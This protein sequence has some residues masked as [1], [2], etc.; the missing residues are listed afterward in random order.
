M[1]LGR[2]L[3]GGGRRSASRAG[4]QQDKAGTAVLQGQRNQSGIEASGRVKQPFTMRV[5]DIREGVL[6]FEDE[7]DAYRYCSLLTSSASP[8]P[9]PFNSTP[10]DGSSSSGASASATSPAD[11]LPRGGGCSPSSRFSARCV[12]VAHFSASEVRP[13]TCLWAAEAN[14]S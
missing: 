8:S 2:D 10:S 1:L 11:R 12:G 3:G 6:V 14:P 13:L 9:P 7:E 4:R 5:D